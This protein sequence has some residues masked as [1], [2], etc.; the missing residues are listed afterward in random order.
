MDKS[1]GGRRGGGGGDRMGMVQ[2]GCDHNPKGG[3]LFGTSTVGK[4]G[5]GGINC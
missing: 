1:W 4:G 3:K 5:V 2:S